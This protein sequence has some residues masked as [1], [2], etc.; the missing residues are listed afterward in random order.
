MATYL[1]GQRSLICLYSRCY[2]RV[3]RLLHTYIVFQMLDDKYKNIHCVSVVF[4]E[5][6][7]L[8]CRIGLYAKAEKKNH[9]Q[10]PQT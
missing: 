3:A 8:G 7:L 4:E 9:K 10:C 1:S 2:V 5:L 6:L